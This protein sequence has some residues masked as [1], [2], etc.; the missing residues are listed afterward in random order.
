MPTNI[1]RIH[2][3]GIG[4]A[5]MSAIAKILL[6]KG[7]TVTG[8]DITKSEAVHRLERFGAKVFIGHCRENIKDVEAI[9]VST[10][11]TADNPEVVAAR[12]RGIKIFHR[13]DMVA[14][15]MN[16]AQ[17]IA[18]A[19][20]HGKT[21]TTS[22]IALMLEKSGLDPTIIIGGDLDYL[23]GNAKWG[24]GKYLVAE[25]D[26]SDGSFIK[27]SP[28]I[29]VVTNI[30]NDHMDHYGTM[31]SILQ[32][33]KDF[34]EKLDSVTGLGILCFDNAYV[35]DIAANINR[36]F[37]SYAVDH[38]A[39][40]MA[41]DITIRGTTTIYTVYHKETKLGT[42]E[43]NVPGRHNVANSL[44]AV[45]V[46]MSVGL[47]F[48]QIAE[49]ISMFRGVK[50]RF[51][52]KGRVDGVWVVD[53]YAHHPTEIATTLQAAR[54]V[55]PKRLICVFQPHRFTRTKLL[56]KEFGGAFGMADILILTDI[57]AA[58]ENPIPGVSGELI[59]DEVERQSGKKA[60][61]I[62]DRANIARYLTE[63]VESGDL[64]MTMGAGN[65]Y[66][67]GEEL[68]EKLVEK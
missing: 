63:I 33:F 40:Y 11:I 44:A 42:I 62:Q 31:E 50:R 54:D 36:K 48:E 24:Q 21:T 27:L 5:G 12:E 46:G 51:Q 3:I 55:K 41:R 38:E 34:L 60:V 39:E 6:Q 1:T 17:G 16:E 56:I 61:Y 25:A 22:I 10:A 52:T 8:S 13:S 67:A 47:S 2:F 9:V 28:H 66:L 59:K 43:L 32:A 20:A 35:R 14:M 19:G 65:I 58:G 45:A 18:V 29:A 7:Y 26:E 68:V 57:Y 49:G 30:E 15:L 4:G 53:D 37:V 64:V 23:N